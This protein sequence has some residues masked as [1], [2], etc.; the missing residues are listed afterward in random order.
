MCDVSVRW[1]N[2]QA[3][4]GEDDVWVTRLLLKP[5]GRQGHAGLG[6]M[7][8]RALAVIGGGNTREDCTE[9]AAAPESACKNM[10]DIAAC[11][12][13]CG[14]H[15]A[16]SPMLLL[17][18]WCEVAALE[19]QDLDRLW[20][21]LLLTLRL[22][23]KE[24]ARVGYLREGAPA[25]LTPGRERAAVLRQRGRQ[26]GKVL[27]CSESTHTRE[28]TDQWWGLC[29]SL[30]LSEKPRT[31]APRSGSCTRAICTHLLS[32][33]TASCRRPLSVRSAHAPHCPA[34]AACAAA[35]T[36]GSWLRVRGSRGP[37]QGILCVCARM[38][39]YS[40]AGL[41]HAV[42]A[43]GSC[44]YVRSVTRLA[45][46]VRAPQAT[47]VCVCVCVW[48]R[49]QLPAQRRRLLQPPHLSSGGSGWWRSMSQNSA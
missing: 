28:M 41:F 15:L 1:Q 17:R 34:G 48:C 22:E 40:V 43:T 25:A 37:G 36:W 35:A 38:C 10:R 31:R 27:W 16:T 29:H 26:G 46:A 6:H 2:T 32:G 24:G 44:V 47:V 21:S 39:V 33:G 8:I 30:T 7:H 9:L 14:A 23:A 5:R 3:S 42:Q 13:Q 20:R 4:P 18:A 11:A 49:A 45:Y 19:A 12:V